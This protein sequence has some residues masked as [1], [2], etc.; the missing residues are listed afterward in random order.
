MPADP[1][2]GQ[3]EW[4]ATEGGFTCA[5]DLVKHIREAH[6][7]HFGICVAGE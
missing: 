3:A 5:L 1:P 2:A 4:K 7:E 6:G